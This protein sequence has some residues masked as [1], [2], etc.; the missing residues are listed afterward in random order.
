MPLWTPGRTLGPED[1]DQ[2]H[3][4][5]D[6]AAQHL[7][8]AG[9]DGVEVERSQM[10]RLLAAEASGGVE[11][12]LVVEDEEALRAMIRE[13]L[14]AEGYTVLQAPDGAGALAVAEAHAGPIHLL[15]T[16]VVMPRL[17]GR[18]LFDRLGALRPGL[19]CVFM[20][21]Y[22]GHAA[23]R[24]GTL[25]EGQGFLDKPFTR[26]GLLRQVREA[27]RAGS[28]SATVRRGGPN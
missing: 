10:E 9:D 21:G 12:L 27:L 20:S 1:R 22:T 8:H 7:F 5:A 25:P 24:N 18:E 3:V 19:R 6:Q 16:D 28:S 14:E 13:I 26:V 23:L 11:T 17:N 4:L 15:V 2:V